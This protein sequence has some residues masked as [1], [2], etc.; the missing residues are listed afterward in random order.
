MPGRLLSPIGSI[1][2]F[3][4]IEIENRGRRLAN[5]TGLWVGCWQRALPVKQGPCMHEEKEVTSVCCPLHGMTSCY[6][7]NTKPMLILMLCLGGVFV[8]A[9]CYPGG[10]PRPLDLDYDSNNLRDDCE[11][12]IF[13]ANP[14]ASYTDADGKTDGEKSNDEEV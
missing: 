1:Q 5:K 10:S 8:S 4:S 14:D 3:V 7:N 9:P 6:M 11:K 2:N 12:F 13:D